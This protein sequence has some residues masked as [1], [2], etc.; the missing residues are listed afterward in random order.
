MQSTYT[1][2]QILK[3]SDVCDKVYDD[4]DENLLEKFKKEIEAARNEPKQYESNIAE[5]DLINWRMA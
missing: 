3:F 2:D 1:K 4:C 5:I